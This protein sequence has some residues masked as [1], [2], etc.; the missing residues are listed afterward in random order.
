MSILGPLKETTR[1]WIDFA[2]ADM[3]VADEL[4]LY[5][6]KI[7]SAYFACVFHCH[8]VIEK[9]LKAHLVES[10]KGGGEDS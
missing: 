6:K 7:G 4:F 3:E 1:K 9:L 5:G 8:Q 10:R 2:K